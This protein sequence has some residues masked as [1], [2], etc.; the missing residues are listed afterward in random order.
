[1]IKHE[2]RFMQKIFIFLIK[3]QISHFFEI[4][5]DSTKISLK[6]EIMKLSKTN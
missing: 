4:F 5:I 1:M 2:E 3:K 6:C